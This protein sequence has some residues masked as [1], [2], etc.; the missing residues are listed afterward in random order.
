MVLCGIR[1]PDF[2][3]RILF[4]DEAI[5]WLNGYVNKQNCRI[6]SEAN[7]QV[8][9]ETPLHPEKL[10]VWCALWAGGIIG[11]FNSPTYFQSAPKRGQDSLLC[12]L[13]K[14]F[15][16]NGI[17]KQKAVEREVEAERH[18]SEGRVVVYRASTPQVLGSI[19][20]LAPCE[21][22]TRQ[23]VRKGH[24]LIQPLKV[25]IKKFR[26]T[27][28]LTIRPDIGSKPVSEEVIT[29]VATEEKTSHGV[30]FVSP[31]LK[32]LEDDLKQKPVYQDSPKDAVSDFSLEIELAILFTP[33]QDPQDIP[34]QLQ[35]GEVVHYHPSE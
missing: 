24:L 33:N 5:F 11:K 20:G 17:V 18:N 26:E 31:P 14:I 3:K 6:W 35:L 34:Q 1:I 13:D 9:V 19:N 28:S 32:T 23:K 21:L 15:K 8:Y 16:S 12:R 30:S 25:T 29:D 22:R 27:E 10:T 4:I 2:H 7:P